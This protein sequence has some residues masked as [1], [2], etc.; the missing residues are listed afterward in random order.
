MIRLSRGL[1]LA[2]CFFLFPSCGV[3]QPDGFLGQVM[4]GKAFDG[5]AKQ[6]SKE[7]EQAKRDLDRQMC[8]KLC[9]D[10]K[11]MTFKLNL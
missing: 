8:S 7:E 1:L 6:P 3:I 4:E 2:P 5:D 10:P 9:E 11:G